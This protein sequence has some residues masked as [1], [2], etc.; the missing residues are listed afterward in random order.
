MIVTG[1]VRADGGYLGGGRGGGGRV[2]AISVNTIGTSGIS[3]FGGEDVLGGLSNL[4]TVTLAHGILT[5][6]ALDFGP[7]R[8]GTRK[9]AFMGIQN[10]GDADTS[11][12]G[13]FPQPTTGSVFSRIGN[14]IFSAL[15]QRRYTA[16]P[17]TFTPTAL[18]DAGQPLSFL[19]DGGNAPVDLLG[20]GVGPLAAA[21]VA[22]GSTIDFGITEAVNVASAPLTFSNATTSNPFLP[23]TLIR[24]TLE[25]YSIT[26]PDADFFSLGGFSPGQTLDA[27]DL[28]AMQV[29]FIPNGATG[30]KT[31]TLTIQ[32]DQGAALGA[33]GETFSFTLNGA[34][35]IPEPGACAL[36]VSVLVCFGAGR[37]KGRRAAR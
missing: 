7:V 20:I 12:N 18:G 13:R 27:G 26:G 24:L 14:G 31:A 9:T 32:S 30:P 15:H 29:Q 5:A 10:T 17:Y 6:T 34:A 22:F 3:V 36:I 11:I 28:A 25:S 8:V 1:T 19:S 35:T 23:G 16:N 21:N 33:A 4:G 37:R 2:A